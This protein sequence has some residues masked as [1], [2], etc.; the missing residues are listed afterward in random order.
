M[1]AS[2]IALNL[3]SYLSYAHIFHLLIA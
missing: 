1:I 3:S 2:L